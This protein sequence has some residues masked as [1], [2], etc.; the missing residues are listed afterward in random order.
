MGGGWAGTAFIIFFGW[1][2]SE[3][4]IHG[5]WVQTHPQNHLRPPKILQARA[6]EARPGQPAGVSPL[7]GRFLIVGVL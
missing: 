2:S 3:V 5:S 1:Q 6:G 7:A 4:I